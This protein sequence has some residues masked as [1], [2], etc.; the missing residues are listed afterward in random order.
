VVWLRSGQILIGGNPHMFA[1]LIEKRERSFF[2]IDMWDSYW[3][4]LAIDGVP[5]DEYIEHRQLSDTTYSRYQNNTPGQP[6][7]WS[8]GGGPFQVV[9]WTEA[10]PIAWDRTSPGPPF[11]PG[12]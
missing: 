4:R 10:W 2:T 7:V 3:I 11:V 9:S 8:N 12:L 6:W 5:S 1:V